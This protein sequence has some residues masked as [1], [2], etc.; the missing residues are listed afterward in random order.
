MADKSKIE[1]TDSTWNPVTGCQKVSPGCDN[2]YAESITIR[3]KRGPFEDVKFHPDRLSIISKWVK[4]RF[5]F[6]NSMGD[7]F[8]SKLANEEIANIFEAMFAN[9]Q[10]TYQVLTKR[11]NRVRRWWDWYQ[12]EFGARE[13]PEN[14]WLGTSIESAEFLPRLER[15]EGIAPVTFISAEPLIGPIAVELMDYLFDRQLLGKK[16]SL[17]WV[18]VGGESGTNPRLMQR[19]WVDQI[20]TVCQTAHIPFFFKQWGGRAP[21]R[22]G[23]ELNGQT[24]DA[25]PPIGITL[26]KPA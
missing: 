3:F 1:W 22:T 11:P 7:T 18:I 14:I 12:C 24:Y 21:K 6:V 26:N 9:P 2:C 16:S 20:R 19:I 13:W 25:M 10:H 17:N 8:H 23:R 15:I 5:I 4:P